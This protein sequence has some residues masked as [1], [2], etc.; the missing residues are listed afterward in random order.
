MANSKTQVASTT[1]DNAVRNSL[2][3]EAKI[4]Q[5]KAL[6]TV[7]SGDGLEHL[8][9]H[10][11]LIQGNVMWLVADLADEIDALHQETARRT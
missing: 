2:K 11:D 3:L 4:I 7:L 10:D 1:N 5:L 6:T 9:M 8:R